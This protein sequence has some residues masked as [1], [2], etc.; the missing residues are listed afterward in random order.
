[1]VRIE[2]QGVVQVRVPYP[3]RSSAIEINWDQR[4]N[5]Y[6][7]PESDIGRDIARALSLRKQFNALVGNA[8]SAALLALMETIESNVRD[9]MSDGGE[10]AGRLYDWALFAFDDGDKCLPYL[11]GSHPEGDW[12]RESRYPFGLGIATW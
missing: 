3:I 12:R 7:D 9:W 6:A 8:P 1:M 11:M 5:V 10:T 4:E 2:S